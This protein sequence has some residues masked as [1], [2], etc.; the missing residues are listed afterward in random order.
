MSGDAAMTKELD[1]K[2]KLLHPEISWEMGKGQFVLSPDGQKALAPVVRRLVAAAPSIPGWNIFAFRQPTPGALTMCVGRHAL[3]A[4]M[5]FFEM[6]DVYPQID[7]RCFLPS[8]PNP[9]KSEREYACFLLMD[10]LIGEEQVIERIRYVDF[11]EA[12]TMPQRALPLTELPNVLAQLDSA[13]R[14]NSTP[15]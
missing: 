12:Q 2:V 6:Q 9:T 11:Q 10:A 14:G 13:H 15:S 4:E 1:A 7:I 5:I 3:S 8:I